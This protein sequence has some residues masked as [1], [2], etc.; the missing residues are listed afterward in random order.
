[1]K[2]DVGI[3]QAMGQSAEDVPYVSSVNTVA[4]GRTRAG[5]VKKLKKLSEHFDKRT[6]QKSADVIADLLGLP[7]VEIVNADRIFDILEHAIAANPANEA[8]LREMQKKI[9]DGKWTGAFFWGGSSPM[10]YVAGNA[11]LAVALE[12][13]AHEM[14]HYLVHVKMAQAPA[15][16]QM[17][18]QADFKA[19][20]RTRFKRAKVP[21]DAMTEGEQHHLYNEWLA[22]QIGRF[23][24]V[25]VLP[26]TPA[27]KLFAELAEALK[28]LISLM[29]QIGNKIFPNAK[30]SKGVTPASVRTFVRAALTAPAVETPPDPA[31]SPGSE[32]VDP[33]EYIEILVNAEHAILLR[34]YNPK[35][36]G[37]HPKNQAAFAMIRHQLD[38]L[39]APQDL[40]EL[41]NI[42]MQPDVQAR[43]RTLLGESEAVTKQLY[44]PYGAAAY[45]Y[46]LAVN[47]LMAPP[48]RAQGLMAKLTAALAN[49]GGSVN[50]TPEEQWAVLSQLA[51][52]NVH[53]ANPIF[54]AGSK[55]SVLLNQRIQQRSSIV[56]SAMFRMSGMFKKAFSWYIDVPHQ[57]LVDTRIPELI[58]L[59][60]VLQPQ[61]W[62]INQF[63]PGGYLE[64]AHASYH[65][66][67]DRLGK[68][69]DS[70]SEAERAELED[71]LFQ[72]QFDA[73]ATST[74][75]NVKDALGKM[76]YVMNRMHEFAEKMQGREL[77]YR[78]NY[79][80]FI[81]DADYVRSNLDTLQNL[82]I[83]TPD[84][85]D[86]WEGV[87]RQYAEWVL[88]HGTE[89][90][91]N[92]P[93]ESSAIVKNMPLNEF[94]R[95][96]LTKSD[97][98]DLPGWQ[99]E[100]VSGSKHHNPAFRFSNPRLLNFM[101]PYANTPGFREAFHH[102]SKEIMQR[103]VKALTKRATFDAIQEALGPGGID[104]ALKLAAR[105][106]ATK[107]Q[108]RVAKDY[109]EAL[110]GF[111]GIKERDAFDGF[112]RAHSRIE[113]LQQFDSEGRSI[114]NPKI[115]ALRN[116]FLFWQ[117]VTKLT[118]S[119]FSS[120]I[121]PLGQLLIHGDGKI[122]ASS[123]KTTYNNL[124]EAFKGNPTEAR[125]M[126]QMVGVM[127]RRF[128][129]EDLLETHLG[130]ETT[131]MLQRF[132]TIMF[133]ANGVEW[134]SNRARESAGLAASTAFIQWSQEAQGNDPERAKLA[135]RR[136]AEFGLKPSD[137]I[138]SD[139]G[140]GPM[141][142]IL[143]LEQKGA[144]G[145]AEW[146]RDDRLRVA[147]NRFVDQA[148]VR[149]DP[150]NRPL[151]AS[152]PYFAVMAQ[153]KGFIT[154]FDNQI[155]RP[156]WARM[157]QEGNATP[158]MWMLLTFI[159]VM[160]FADMVR[161]AIKTAFD[162]DDE[163]NRPTWKDGWTLADHIAY[164]VQRA[165]LY[166]RFELVDD[167]ITPLMNGKI[168]EAAAELLGPT[169]SDLRKVNKY[170]LDSLPTPFQDA[171]GAWE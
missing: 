85:R 168:P 148:Q 127:E 43:M 11:N 103:Y 56:G 134:V 121:D 36:Q 38:K 149:P 96:Y 84:L 89:I 159:P 60:R 76:T 161:D 118:L 72:R 58:R 138:W 99:L 23:I 51:R 40:R 88:K 98:H 100:A 61:A 92:T 144:V 109:V 136:L 50:Y 91:G 44:E 158:L 10:I 7:R 140:S 46:M 137:V 115:N 124:V 15:D 150:A 165:G 9:L 64:R 28:Q 67:A 135:T 162:E 8:A 90:D 111:L 52:R 57:R 2:A 81:P 157:E 167:I 59:A 12:T 130:P 141:V 45:L 31:S 35:F 154:A 1:M 22:D 128:A 155:L 132:A 14:G 106:G 133:R 73:N 82:F 37:D 113:W 65:M 110:N 53:P 49:F 164:S 16:L 80:P 30:W 94:V 153:W 69:I 156:T 169:A 171:I 75:Q 20:M 119:V 139:T 13:I 87:R 160:F 77:N 142:I 107:E 83:S 39:L 104:G 70:L 170:G 152:N 120:L 166:G 17:Q 21:F 68:I 145:S 47:G 26:K 5:I 48:Q 122:F 102:D 125:R 79:W 105:Q 93:A 25:D 131:P 24:V 74:N 66:F 78:A 114:V 116:F 29:E 143:E 71:L 55:A 41:T 33:V 54:P 6:Y 108:L 34:A 123:M 3:L 32:P 95:Y 101:L 42:A 62:E 97:I 4:D 126:L 27:E 163:N 112:I 18:I 146:E 151:Y 19:E 86:G 117:M 63:K 147:I 129:S